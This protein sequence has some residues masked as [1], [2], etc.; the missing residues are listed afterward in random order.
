MAK[1]T[2][3][4]LT[5]ASASNTLAVGIPSLSIDYI[6]VCVI[7]RNNVRSFGSH[8]SSSSIA[9]RHK[10]THCRHCAQLYIV[11]QWHHSVPSHGNAARH[12]WLCKCTWECW[13]AISLTYSILRHGEWRGASWLLSRY[14]T[15][16]PPTRTSSKYAAYVRCPT[17]QRSETCRW[18]PRYIHL[19]T[20]VIR[21]KLTR[22]S[23][24]R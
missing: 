20:M 10:I 23:K 24:E 17:P 12:I 1:R 22:L 15:R 16:A 9:S 5:R 6:R 11:Q 18:S 21:L 19:S 4:D 2:C 13:H 7:L 14:P 3:H 8:F